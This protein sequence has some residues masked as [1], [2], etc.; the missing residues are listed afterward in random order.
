[1]GGAAAPARLL[2]A[3]RAAGVPVVTNYGMT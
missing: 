2:P 3:A 1:L